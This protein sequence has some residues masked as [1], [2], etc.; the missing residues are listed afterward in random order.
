MCEW[1]AREAFRPVCVTSSDTR[2]IGALARQPRGVAPGAYPDVH[3]G[4]HSR[5]RKRLAVLPGSSTIWKATHRLGRCSPLPLKLVS[6]HHGSPAVQRHN[7]F[8]QLCQ[9][10]HVARMHV[11]PGSGHRRCSRVSRAIR[12]ATVRLGRKSPLLLKHVSHHDGSTAVRRP[13]LLPHLR[14]RLPVAAGS[15][16]RR[17]WIA[18]AA[19]AFVGPWHLSAACLAVGPRMRLAHQPCRGWS[20][21]PLCRALHAHLSGLPYMAAGWP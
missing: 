13:K 8:S 7:W 17:K 3:T 21:L 1:L 9:R 12:H 11:A 14:K 4:P 15:G 19:V 6:H 2:S 16:H 20:W 5:D 10:V 18:V